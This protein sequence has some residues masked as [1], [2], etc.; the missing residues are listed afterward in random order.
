MSA[1]V[2]WSGRMILA[3]GRMIYTGPLGSTEE[4]SH[5][6][7]QLVVGIS[8]E[9]TVRDSTGSLQ[10]SRYTLIPADVPHALLGAGQSGMVMYVDA[11]GLVGRRIVERFGHARRANEW[12]GICTALEGCS[13]ITDMPARDT[14]RFGDALLRTLVEPDDEVEARHPAVSR[15]LK[16]VATRIRERPD[17]RVDMAAVAKA[18]GLS[19][20]RLSH[21]FGRQVGIPF[22]GYVLWHRLMLAAEEVRAGATLTSA[23][24]A[25][26]FTDSA[27]LH[28]VFKRMFGVAPSEGVGRVGWETVGFG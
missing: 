11:D 16:V 27:H 21:V 17:V 25:A 12:S 20:S 1:A 24:H 28:H 22:R 6:A 26:G 15:A 3:P 5:H 13:P 4:H 14:V 8:S 2:P 7:H 23:A 19:P 9:V 10:S 18:V